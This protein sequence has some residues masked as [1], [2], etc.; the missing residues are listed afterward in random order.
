MNHEHV[1]NVGK[2]IG[3]PLRVE[4]LEALGGLGIASPNELA[5]R[6]DG[7]LTSVSYH[8]RMLRDYGAIELVDTEPRRGALEHYYR[9]TDLGVTAADTAARLG[10][11]A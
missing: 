3:H 1:T 9:R 10:E 4:L 2:A 5:K 7:P 11:A 8:V 6:L